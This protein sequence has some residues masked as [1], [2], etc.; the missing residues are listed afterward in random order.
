MVLKLTKLLYDL[1]FFLHDDL[2]QNNNLLSLGF[3]LL[4]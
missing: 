4:L 1:L 3:N 2:L